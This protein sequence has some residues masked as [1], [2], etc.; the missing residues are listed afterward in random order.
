MK[1]ESK[2]LFI[3]NVMGPSTLIRAN[4][5]ASYAGQGVI[6]KNVGCLKFALVALIATSQLTVS[7]VAFG[8]A[9]N[10]AVECPI[11]FDDT[12]QMLHAD[13][14]ACAGCLGEQI[15]AAHQ[16]RNGANADQ[17]LNCPARG[18][19]Y[20]I[21]EADVQRII[22]G[23]LAQFR[24]IQQARAERARAVNQKVEQ[25]DREN[26]EWKFNNTKPCPNCRRAIEK[27]GGCKWV[28]CTGCHREFCYECLHISRPGHL[29]EVHNP[30]RPVSVQTAW[31]RERAQLNAPNTW[32]IAGGIALVA[33]FWGITELY[34]WFKNRKAKK[35][36][37]KRQPAARRTIPTRQT[38][39][40]ARV[41]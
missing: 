3:F 1:F 22:P 19:Q 18:C 6:M 4:S 27:N 12:D 28:N 21:T 32:V 14:A 5:S 10:Q 37:V 7:H 29:H 13:H 35:V 33:A 25:E 36:T 2:W 24:E 30:C 20:Q 31:A 16:N 26:L 9:Q 8:M 17:M 38:R 23:H 39:P 40:A 11:C 15:D 34:S 41:R